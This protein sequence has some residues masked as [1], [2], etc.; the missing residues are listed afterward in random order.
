MESGSPNCVIVNDA[1]ALIDLKKGQLLH[2]LSELP[3]Q[4]IVPL[5]IR[6][7]E[8]TSFSGQDWQ[9]LEDGGLIEHDLT[10]D[11]VTEAQK[12]SANNPTLSSHDCFCWVTAKLYEDSIVLTGDRQLRI[13]CEKSQIEVHGVLWVVD[14]LHRHNCCDASLLLTA[15]KIWQQDATVRLPTNAISARIKIHSK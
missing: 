9:L 11:Q 15:L 10:G 1:N 6:L 12:L 14:E 4:L 2:V 7:E 8:V 13:L 3:Y 5:P